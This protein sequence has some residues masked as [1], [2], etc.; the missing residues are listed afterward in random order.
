MCAGVNMTVKKI[1]PSSQSRII[2]RLEKQIQVFSD[3]RRLQQQHFADYKRQA[4]QLLS[5]A[6]DRAKRQRDA[7]TNNNVKITE[8]ENQV[9]NQYRECA[10]SRSDLVHANNIRQ[11]IAEELASKNNEVAAL[12]RD[13]TSALLEIDNLRS[14]QP[15]SLFRRVFG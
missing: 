5:D 15:R 8:L 2:R 4:E 7:L 12:E 14:L 11:R 3:S 13:L 9:A 1:K 10:Q 6:D